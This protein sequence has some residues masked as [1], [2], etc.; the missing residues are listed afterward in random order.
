[1]DKLS[2]DELPP[3]PERVGPYRIESRL[4]VGG[5]GAVYRAYDQR[6][7]RPVAIKH[8]LPDVAED[9]KARERLRREARAVASLNH[10]SIVQIF[11]IVEMDE[12]DWIVMELV[13]GQTLHRLLSRGLLELGKAVDLGRQIIEGLAEAHGKG[14][15]HRDLKTENVMVTIAGRAK[16]LDF[17]LAKR[18][19]KGRADAS[20]SVQGSILGTGRAM[21]PEQAMG[22]TID[23]RS[24][25]FS[26]GSMLYEITA[27]R[28]PFMGSSIFHTLAQVCSDRQK[29]AQEVNPRV[30]TVLS[31]LIDQL[32]EKNP[33]QR[34]Q[35]ASEVASALAEIGAHLRLEGGSAVVSIPPQSTE[36]ETSTAG[37]GETTADLEPGVEPSH[38]RVVRR[39]PRAA[40]Q[41]ETSGIFIKTLVRLS[42]AENC[43]ADKDDDSRDFDDSRVYEVLSRHDRLVRDL[44]VDG[45][46]LE[47]EKSEGF[48]LLFDRPADAVRFAV[49][50]QAAL[51]EL[52][53][54]LDTVLAA[55]CAIHLGEV[56][57][58][59]NSRQD[60]TRGAKTLDVEGNTKR[61][62]ARV[63]QLTR[64]GQVL[65][66]QSAFELARRALSGE[67]V[68]GSELHWRTHGTF[69]V[70][71]VDEPMVLCEVAVEGRSDFRPPGAPSSPSTTTPVP[72]SA[73]VGRRFLLASA[74][75]LFV[76]L[77]MWIL[78][79]RIP[80]TPQSGVTSRS[81][82]TEMRSAVAVL[83]LKNLSRR[84]E[85]DWLA[86]AL[87]ETLATELAIGEQLRLIPGES[88]ARMRKELQF[89]EFRSLERDTLVAVGRN[90]ST[91]FV[92]VGSYISLLEGDVEKLRF[93]LWLQPTSGVG[94]PIL[95]TVSREGR[96]S[97]MLEMVK[98][99]GQSL[100]VLLGVEAI[101]PEQERA[102]EAMVEVS[103]E[104]LRLYSEGLEKLR[105]YETQK[106]LELLQ[107]AVRVEPEHALAHNALSEAWRTLGY[108]A[109]AE[110]SARRASELAAGLPREYA[111]QIE[112]N[113]NEVASHWEEAI[114]NY[115]ALYRFFPDSIDYGLRLARAQS[116]AGKGREARETLADLRGLDP[117]DPR[118]D[119]VEAGVAYALFDYQGSLAAARRA[120]TKAEARSASILVAEA[121]SAQGV[122]LMQLTS[123]EEAQEVL[124]KAEAQFAAAGDYGR[125]AVAMTTRATVL[126]YLGDVSAAE[127][128][129][130]EA[131]EQ[132]QEIG[133]RREISTA[134]NSLALLY[135]SVGRLD[136]ARS[137]LEEA[138]S[139][140]REI[141]D[142]NQEA[143][144]LDSLV[145]VVFHQ[146][147]LAEARQLAEEEREAY[148]AIGSDG[149][150]AWSWFYLGR[151]ALSRGSVVEA[152]QGLEKALVIAG[153][154]DAYQEAFLRHGFAEVLLAA[155]DLERA[156]E[157]ADLAFEL[158]RDL[159]EK[160][161][162]ATTRLLRAEIAYFTDPM[163][164]V[165]LKL[166]G[167]LA[168]AAA[169][170]FAQVGT[171]DFE[172]LAY[173]WAARISSAQGR[174]DEARRS[175]ARAQE[176]GG[177]SQYPAVRTAVA[178]ASAEVGAASDA[179]QAAI[180]TAL[181]ELDKTISDLTNQGL[182][183]LA[184]EARWTRHRIAS[185]AGSS[186]L[187]DLQAFAA[188]AADHGF[189]L[190][191]RRTQ[192]L[193]STDTP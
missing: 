44:L 69:E 82:S 76:A 102:V 35:S 170:E 132:L 32:L 123:Q 143:W 94:D 140:S 184:L 99:A 167:E 81:S 2:G 25:L 47:V 145:W 176:L 21:S 183:S 157:E 189:E 193:I 6:L 89:V 5:M 20:L 11:D 103:P 62:V 128:L 165:Q 141:G 45:D 159:D 27:G 173:A 1:M 179:T 142:R 43:L 158:R 110:E 133:N 163:A 54:E 90:L 164:G 65:V 75:L 24:D 144:Y 172:A 162:L 131:L 129:H 126:H 3:P 70:E 37:V 112:G 116:R 169:A 8:I 168:A 14:I 109:R 151:I 148:E 180:D 59:E 174:V 28:P 122:A 136:Q 117:R 153:D 181:A 39:G 113:Y 80:E 178:V 56:F 127:A 53:D 26:F 57:L 19:W 152:R 74:A 51:E 29:P 139:T 138:V 134:Q 104:A 92:V 118:I 105:S 16:I 185:R 100:R 7:E 31:D 95:G 175:L 91:D 86:T 187:E 96:R 58:R 135:Q 150:R 68:E 52:S 154:S 98:D 67:R 177:A 160:G 9:S 188:E 48:L 38:T 22:D 119:L 121:L 73:P 191:A 49:T 114:K 155:G 4:G 61:V 17:G 166:A 71:G 161:S 115:D 137:L 83:E 42:L 77:L 87:A 34:P 130:Q 101:T 108:D 107:E 72:A 66:T 18:L 40:G 12:G 30:P 79:Y 50:H 93:D 182:V 171:P 147:H 15:V 125:R 55:R 146:G 120:E 46:G 111:L 33:A 10:P 64:G 84:P 60:V 190:I 156:R 85:A 88:V 63:E 149:G 36:T 192:E 186:S 13:E 124:L 97:E 23:H 78:T 41:L 106:A